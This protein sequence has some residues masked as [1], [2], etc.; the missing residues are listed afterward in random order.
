MSTLPVFAGATSRLHADII[1]IRLL[2]AG[3]RPEHLSAVFLRRRAPNSVCCWLRGFFQVAQ[4]LASVPMAAAGPLAPVLKGAVS[5]AA[6]MRGLEALGLESHHVQ[7]LLEKAS[8]GQVALCV[9]ARNETEA[10]IA[11]H[12]FQHVAAEDITCP[13]LGSLQQIPA[14]TTEESSRIVLAA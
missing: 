9:H 3:I 11:W 13:A 2:R 1:L 7:Q 8:G 6:A 12:I 14:A 10:V 4:R 5:A